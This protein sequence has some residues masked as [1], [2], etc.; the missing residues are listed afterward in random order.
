MIDQSALLAH[1]VSLRPAREED[2]PFLRALFETGR[3][4][5]AVLAAWP[6]AVRRAFLDQQ[7]HFQTLHYARV[8][9]DADRLIVIA[10]GT[11]VGRL[12]IWRTPAQWYLVDIALVP[13]RRGQGV[14][15]LL[16]QTI[17]AEA[18]RAGAPCLR[19]TVDM[20]NPA[21]RLYERLGFVTEEER[22]PAVAMR[23]PA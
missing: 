22:I 16:L 18:R 7:F 14:G 12:I 4:D 15:T 9:A 23:W 8:Y 10:D 13:A 11:P 20:Q 21:R 2:V 17:Q 5:A 3:L 6:E 1:G 19:L